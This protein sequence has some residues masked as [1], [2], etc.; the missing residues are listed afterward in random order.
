MSQFRD[1]QFQQ[2]S[3]GSVSGG[4]DAGNVTGT[5][6]SR[7]IAFSPNANSVNSASKL[8]QTPDRED[9]KGLM[10]FSP[11]H[12][13]GGGFRTTGMSADKDPFVTPSSKSKMKTDQQLSATASSFRPFYDSMSSDGSGENQPQKTEGQDLHVSLPGQISHSLSTDIFMSRCVEFSCSTQPGPAEIDEFIA[14]RILIPLNLQMIPHW[15]SV[16]SLILISLYRDLPRL[17]GLGWD[18]RLSTPETPRYTFTTTTFVT[19]SSATKMSIFVVLAG[20]RLSCPLM[21]SCR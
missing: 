12:S 3:P 7:L 16:Y 20:R 15:P 21:I 2:S 6:T 5:P 17:G 4:G 13:S 8:I 14:V 11:T 10:V 19:P 1:H 18:T 9:A